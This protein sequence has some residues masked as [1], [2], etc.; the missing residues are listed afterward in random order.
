MSAHLSQMSDS[1]VER[2]ALVPL[3]QPVHL[4]VCA[5]HEAVSIE[6]CLQALPPQRSEGAVR[7]DARRVLAGR[8]EGEEA[9][10]RASLSPAP[11]TTSRSARAE[12]SD[13]PQ[14]DMVATAV[15]PQHEPS[16]GLLAHSSL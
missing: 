11:R 7:S 8:A 10:G 6:S 4:P 3:R 15:E 14:P 2:C 12:R 1:V 5:C 9:E 16:P 13:D